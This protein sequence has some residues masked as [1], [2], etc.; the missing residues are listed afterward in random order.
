VISGNTLAGIGV[1]DDSTTGNRIV[2]NYIGT[3]FSGTRA[4]GN[5]GGGIQVSATG[6]LFRGNLI[7]GNSECG[8]LMQDSAH[9]N[10]FVENRIG[11][12]AG[13]NGPLPNQGSGVVFTSGAYGDTIGPGNCIA[14]NEAFGIFLSDST[15]QAITITENAVTAN[16]SGAVYLAPGA[17]GRMSAPELSGEAPLSGIAPP[18]SRVEIFSDSGEQGGQFE[19]VV[20]ADAGGVWSWD[21]EPAGPNVTATATDTLGNSSCFSQIL[22]VSVSSAEEATQPH[23]WYLDQNYP[24]PFNP[25][26]VISFGVKSSGH[27]R[28]A[29]YNILGREVRTVLDRELDAGHYRIPFRADGLAAGIYFYRII[30]REFRAVRKMV[31][32][33]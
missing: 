1:L 21:G 9:A 4:L 6:N 15:V 7:S 32:L 29:V 30:S 3:D 2:D 8:I 20:L 26:T 16:G 17:N 31:I 14:C 24:N 13:G 28:L 33:D 22:V 18:F 10:L 12:R 5:E 19:G 25:E 27:V 11:T 23:S